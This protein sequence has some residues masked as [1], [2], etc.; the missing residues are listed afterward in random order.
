MK[1]ID[2]ATAIITL[3]LVP[4]IF[5]VIS[6]VVRWITK[7]EEARTQEAVDAFLVDKEDRRPVSRSA[8]NNNAGTGGQTG[9]SDH[10]LAVTRQ[11]HAGL[12]KRIDD[13]ERRTLIADDRNFALLRTYHSQGLAQSKIS[14]WFS[15]VL[16]VAGFGLIVWAVVLMMRSGNALN[17]QGRATVPLIAGTITE[18]V[19]T[20]FFVQSNNTRKVMTTFF[21]KLRLDRNLDESLR[22]IDSVRDPK[23]Q[24][25]LQAVIAIH[26]VDAKL[27]PSV[28]PGFGLTPRGSSHITATPKTRNR[29]GRAT[30]QPVPSTQTSAD[31]LAGRDIGSDTAVADRKG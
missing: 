21:D 19:S 22:L 4:T 7:S 25:S 9:A 2:L 30:T 5:V 17:A 27:D 28:L 14:F 24:G 20:L 23:L 1:S 31:Q 10:Q 11:Q 6:Q 26:L 15:L 16:G 18:A 29:K 8:D 12:E 3:T 13:L